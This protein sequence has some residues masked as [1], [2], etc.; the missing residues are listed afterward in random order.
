MTSIDDPIFYTGILAGVKA[1]FSSN[2]YVGY[3]TL[4][5]VILY[6]EDIEFI[7]N[8]TYMPIFYGE[9][10]ALARLKKD[11]TES[12]YVKRHL[13]TMQKIA[14]KTVSVCSE[15]FHTVIDLKQKTPIRERSVK[16]L[17]D[18]T[19]ILRGIVDLFGKLED[20]DD[21]TH[22]ALKRMRYNCIVI[23]HI[24]SFSRSIVSNRE[25]DLKRFKELLD[26][27]ESN[28]VTKVLTGPP[29]E[30]SD[31]LFPDESIRMPKDETKS[32][33]KKRDRD[34]SES[35]YGKSYKR[36]TGHGPSDKFY[37][38]R[39]YDRSESRTHYR[40]SKE[41][42]Y[43]RSEYRSS[44][45][46][47]R[48]ESRTPYRSEYRSDRRSEYRSEHVVDHRK[49]HKESPKVSENNSDGMVSSLRRIHYPT[50]KTD[51][52]PAEK[53]ADYFKFDPVVKPSKE[54]TTPSPK[55][56]KATDPTND[57]RFH[58]ET[59]IKPTQQQPTQQQQ[60]D[61]EMAKAFLSKLFS[62]C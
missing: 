33:S 18:V 36:D 26:N 45:D 7:A 47:D 49:K 55:V 3:T 8:P 57:T 5:A 11:K 30:V 20:L 59:I 6:G 42:D 43:Y 12:I 46:Y 25:T 56:P 10:A 39:Y 32:Q 52:K 17:V 61:E 14:D 58:F 60:S 27:Y 1:L 48:S 21:T 2:H 44:K 37:R 4:V 24:L 34:E 62:R 23:A 54:N 13:E 40:S 22:L 51:D 41:Y 38:N 53:P 15:I 28:A 16:Y 29:K 35:R 50:Y 19:Y 9:I 31:E